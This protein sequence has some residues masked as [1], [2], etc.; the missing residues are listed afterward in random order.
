M[1]H[2]YE[3][4]GKHIVID[5]AS[6]AV[7][8]TNH[9]A[10][11]AI[12]QYEH[13]D[14]KALRA[15]L[16]TQ[17]PDTTEDTLSALL[18]EIETLK[19]SNQLFSSEEPYKEIAQT[20]KHRGQVKALCLH[21]ANN[22]NLTCSY[23]FAGADKHHGE[24]PL[25]SFEV[26]KQA[27]D[28]LV[29]HSGTRRNLEVDFFG[30][31]PLLNWEVVTQIVAYG[32]QL[33]QIH[34][35]HFRFTLTTNGLLLNDTMINYINEEMETVV[36]SLDGRPE[37]HDYFRKTKNGA[38][39]YEIVIEKFQ[40]LVQA[41]K[42]GAYHI[43]GTFTKR[44]LDFL[45]DILH[46]RA[47]GFTEISMEPVVCDPM[48]PYAITKD[49]LPRIFKEYEALA[50]EMAKRKGTEDAFRFYHYNLGIAGGPC[51]HKRLVGCGAGF[52]YLAVTPTGQLFPCH[53]FLED[54][55]FLL[56]DV[57]Q[58]VQNQVPAEEIANLNVFTRPDC[59]D[60]WAKL[61]CGGGCAANAYHASGGVRG[62]DQVGCAMFQ[63]RLECATWLSCT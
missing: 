32:R 2:Q 28:F 42:K 43:R 13:H 62:I 57:W 18:D 17:F 54:E 60:C 21:I 3:L 26:G 31:E 50:S 38:G 40:K 51:V 37:V 63:K 11:T 24:N 46:I 10:Y 23:C 27:L 9:L 30:G 22:C 48:L 20:T 39:S 35:K 45:Q 55:A 33:E 7:H 19:E 1:L 12:A 52:E 34:D 58:G 25:M 5:T 14:K 59:I 29:S 61:Y 49:D 47:L 8:Q 44:N 36:L 15:L 4:L 41:R 53:Q 56:G 16:H 6:G